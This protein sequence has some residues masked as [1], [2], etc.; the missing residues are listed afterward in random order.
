MK[1]TYKLVGIKGDYHFSRDHDTEFVT[2]DTF[3]SD[4]TKSGFDGNYD[5]IIF[6]SQSKNVNSSD[7]KFILPHSIV[8]VFSKD[9][10]IKI[11][12]KDIFEKNNDS[13]PLPSIKPRTHTS[14]TSS[15]STSNF[16]I[17]PTQ[18][19]KKPVE[20]KI[21]TI[22]DDEMIQHNKEILSVLKDEDFIT[23]MKIYHN[24]PELLS[25]MYNYVS[26]GNIVDTK[27]LNEVED[28]MSEEEAKVF[29]EVKALSESFSFDVN[30]DMIKKLIRGF[31]GN[32]SLIF[33]YLYQDNLTKKD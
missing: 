17:L 20:V 25:F 4:I 24:K 11:K 8:F 23:L 27:D 18:D 29:T 33:R 32:C 12:L 1:V 10:S 5:N 26:S 9:V 7:I 3:K 22:E 21:P 31:N 30:D 2:L 14:S 15:S 16:T 13:T 19:V 28:D 6:I